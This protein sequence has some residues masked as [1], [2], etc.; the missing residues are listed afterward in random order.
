MCV[1]YL[2]YVTFSRYNTTRIKS[3]LPAFDVWFCPCRRE[4]RAVVQK[5]SLS[6]KSDRLG[7]SSLE[8]TDVGFCFIAWV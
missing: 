8:G 2:C 7:E 6:R 1:G 4:G 5:Y 3:A